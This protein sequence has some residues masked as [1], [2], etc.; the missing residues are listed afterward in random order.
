[1]PHR[2][3]VRIVLALRPAHRGHL[4]VHHRCHHLQ[5]GAHSHREQP[6]LHLTGQLGHHDRDGLRHG[7]PHRGSIVRLV[8]LLHSGPLS[9]GSTWRSPKHLPQR[10]CRAAD[11]H[12]NFYETRANLLR[13]R[14]SLL[15]ATS[16]ATYS[17]STTSVYG[18]H[19]ESWRTWRS[20]QNSFRTCDSPFAR[21][22]PDL[23]MSDQARRSPAEAGVV[24]T[25]GR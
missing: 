9:V 19:N 23:G 13:R 10:R 5:P 20:S 14:S 7:Q 22:G 4:G 25:R 12:L 15:M 3:P 8:V 24:V 1:M 17:S 16:S 6:L 2:T 11:R 21:L 18:P